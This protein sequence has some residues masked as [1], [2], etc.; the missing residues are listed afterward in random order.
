MPAKKTAAPPAA[1]PNGLNKPL[2]PS[3]ELAEI[4]GT[5]QL[6]RGEVV[7]KLWEYI[8]KHNLQDPADKRTIVADVKLKPVFGADRVT[9]FEMNKHVA[10]HLS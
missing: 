10:R 2:T 8:K 6:S 4:V 3:K 9:M 7:S 1:K 5:A